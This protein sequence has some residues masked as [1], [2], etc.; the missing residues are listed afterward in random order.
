M[1][2]GNGMSN[3][4]FIKLFAFVTLFL[5]AAPFSLPRLAAASAGSAKQIESGRRSDSEDAS[6]AALFG[7]RWRLTE[8]RGNAVKTTKAYVAFNGNT[9]RYGGHGGCNMYSGGFEISASNLKLSP[10][11]H[12]MMGCREIQQVEDDFL[13]ALTQSTGFQIRDDIL[14]LFAD[15]SP[16]LTFELEATVTGTVTYWRPIALPQEAV[17]EVKLLDVSHADA[18]ATVSE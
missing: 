3:L 10:A 4:F 12:T 18:P 6:G 5:A 8:V 7:R 1:P 11:V 14:R 15:G 9:K 17:V 2:G 16:I 13:K